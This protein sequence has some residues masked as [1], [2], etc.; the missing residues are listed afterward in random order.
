MAKFEERYS[1]KKMQGSRNSDNIGRRV[2]S[3]RRMSNDDDRR[4][5]WRNSE[6][7]HRPSNGRNDY[8][9]YQSENRVQS[10]NFSRGDRR[11]R[12]SSRNC[13]RIQG[14]GG[15]LNVLR[16]RDEPDDQSQPAKDVPIK[17]CLRCNS[18][19]FQF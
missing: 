17:S 18:H 8:R 11:K 3:E 12:G 4:R 6:V 5:N 10:E 15:R 1:C 14:K 13:R 16:V 7:L 2:G 19:K 9:G